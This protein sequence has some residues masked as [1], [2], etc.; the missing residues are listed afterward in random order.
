MRSLSLLGV[1]L[2]AKLLVLAGREVSIS[3][4]SIPALIWQDLVVVLGFAALDRCVGRRWFGWM[5]Y[6]SI[7]LYVSLNVPLIRMFSSP[8]TWT[9]LRAARG[10]LSDS[11]R[12]H[13]IWSNIGLILLVVSASAGLP[14]LLHRVSWRRQWSVPVVTGTVI[15]LV[16]GLLTTTRFE[17][18]GLH[19][20]A[21]FTLVRSALPRIPSKR[22]D[23]D[24]RARPFGQE[25]T[26]ELSCLRGAA[27]GRNVV[28]ILLESTG[29]EYLKLYGAPDDP[30]PNLTALANQSLVVAN[31]YSVYPESIKGLF[32]VLCS[33]YPAL[34][35]KPGLYA[36]IRTP[37]IAQVLGAA[38][39]RTALFHSGRFMYLGMESIVQNRGYEILE[40]AGAISGNHYSSFGVEEPSTIRRILAWIDSLPKD[41]KFFLTYLPIA[42]HH[43]YEAP[44]GGPYPENNDQGRYRNS[45]HYG[46]A[47]LGELID[48]LRRRG[49]YQTTL[50]VVLGDHGEAFG[51]HEGNYGHTLFIYEENVRV[52]FLIAAPGLFEKQRTIRRTI[53]LLDTAPTILDLLG[54]EIPKDY[55]GLSLVEGS[56]ALTL[57]YTDYSLG[58]L[59]LRD[60]PWKYIYEVESA[61]SKLFD[62]NKDPHETTN[63]AA[64]F[65]D[66]V[67]TYRRHLR[68]WSAA[69]KE[70]LQRG[71]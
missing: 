20:N 48:G 12:H 40:D 70:R 18:A 64:H 10:T 52:P 32:S 5:L 39:Y 8:L 57:F 36:S 23:Q 69:Q 29:A 54:M 42:G 55:Q 49:L 22:A 44:E 1:L 45:L 68:L 53:S 16:A 26:D 34:D 43:P 17:T 41:A 28:L 13:L 61:R 30:A 35:T 37:L 47:A 11:I 4:G 19:R 33:R 3:L 51:Q 6:G 63:L 58:F 15:V 56:D 60:G 14:I 59:G 46:D 71:N 7:V 62:L 67:E 66:R 24:W 9:M 21:L 25:K 27:A 50:F 38:G 31:A 2:L 65:P